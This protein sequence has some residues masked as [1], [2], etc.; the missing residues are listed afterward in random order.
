MSSAI[1]PMKSPNASS[2]KKKKKHGIEERKIDVSINS[3]LDV[4]SVILFFLLKSYTSSTITIKP[5]RDLQV[6]MTY[7]LAQVE[8][9]TAVTITLK[10]IL[11]DDNPVMEL[12]DGKPAE[13]D[14][15]QA[16]MLITPLFNK[17][18]EEVAHQ[19]K[20]EQYNKK[21]PFKGIVTIIGDRNIP[22][23]TLTSIMYTA[24]QAQF[25]VFKFLL[26]KTERS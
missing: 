7:S 12:T 25:S 1:G 15:E 3:L 8:E 10:G 4:L 9:S 17:L 21:A 26:I 2:G 24:G 11:V 13:N 5:S 20:I 18:Q 22:A 6:P 23:T 16:G 14:T 19:K